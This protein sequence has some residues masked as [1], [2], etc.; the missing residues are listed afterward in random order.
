AEAR[1]E[2]VGGRDALLEQRAEAPARVRLEELRVAVERARELA[3]ARLGV[4]VAD[5]EPRALPVVQGERA[6]PAHAVGT[7]D[8]LPWS[9]E[10]ERRGRLAHRQLAGRHR[11][12]DRGEGAGEARI[13]ALEPRQHEDRD[14]RVELGVTR[15]P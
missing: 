5:E 3:A 10:R 6:V 13:V 12:L 1:G 7:R 2:L 9:L 15:D 11:A 4:R 8:V 14:E